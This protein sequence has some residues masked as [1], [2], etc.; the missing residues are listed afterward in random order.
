M[1]ARDHMQWWHEARYGMFIHWGVYSIAARGEWVM[2]QEHIP[3]DEYARLSKRFVPKKYDPDEW[4]ALAK[5]AGMKYMVMTSRHHDGFSLFDTQAS[6]FSA[7][8]TAARRDLLREYVEACHRGG[9]RVGFYYS[10]L[11]WR[12]PAYFRGPKGDP[13]GWQELVDYVHAQVREL[14]TNYGKIDLLWYDGGW[15]YTAEDWRS[16]E[17]NAMVRGL[18]P[19]IVI[20]NR[21][22][23]PEDYDTPEQ[24]IRASEAGRAWEACMTLNDSWGYNAA[25][26]NWK[27]AKQV[28]KNL[29]TC[30]SSG[31][32]LLL[33]VGPKPDGTIPKESADV[34]GKVGRWLRRNGGAVYGTARSPFGGTSTGLTTLKGNTLFMHVL[35]WPGREIQFCRIANKVRSAHL[36]ETGRELSFQQNGDRLLVRGL[37]PNAPD[38]LATV[39]VV[40][41]EG[42]PQ[43][44]DYF[45]DGWAVETEPLSV[46]PVAP[47]PPE[48]EE[49]EE[50]T[51]SDLSEYTESE[52]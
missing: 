31:G 15:P 43:T 33:N 17:L 49:P 42:E 37:S 13:Q 29:L 46:E 30:V 8:K 47:A 39:I 14:C 10:L 2:Y 48:P 5:Q 32:N 3:A 51:P 35:R 44:L 26:D 23:L 25:D 12:Y 38:R 36:L 1:G 27:T 40:E 45:A 20:N 6:D 4:V 22:Q 11:D 19:A 21:S 24:H 7:P 9:M 16:E 34:L 18:Q 28:L 52:D 50:E 41:L